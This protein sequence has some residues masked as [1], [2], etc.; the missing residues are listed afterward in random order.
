MESEKENGTLDPEKGSRSLAV[1]AVRGAVEKEELA[2]ILALFE[3][4]ESRPHLPLILWGLRSE[5]AIP[6]LRSLLND[7]SDFAR[8]YAARALGD[9]GVKDAAPELV[10]LLRDP[11]RFAR[12]GALRAVADLGLREAVPFLLTV[13]EEEA[14]GWDIPELLHA[15]EALDAREA[16]PWVRDLLEHMHPEIRI[17]AASWMCRMGG[18]KEGIP[19][20]FEEGASLSP[21]NALRAPE[22][23]RKL[24]QS[25][26]T[27]VVEGRGREVL[28]TVARDAGFEIGWSPAALD[29]FLGLSSGKVISGVDGWSPATRVEALEIGLRYDWRDRFE[30]ILEGDRI[31]IVPYPEAFAFW[32]AWWEERSEAESDPDARR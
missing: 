22:L 23:W 19:V 15:F 32:K 17:A 28:E 2:R 24:S 18:E 7:P 26:L 31:R 30:M 4:E 8:R 10:R 9:L 16:A 13:V 11:E 27:R 3:A 5:E 14:E 25:R 20:L 6:H 21:M 1:L 29:D 12:S